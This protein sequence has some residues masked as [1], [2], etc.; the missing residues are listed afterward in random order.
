MITEG[1]IEDAIS[2][3]GNEIH[4]NAQLKGFWEEPVN[5]DRL[6]LRICGEVAELDE[7]LRD[8]NPQSKKIPQFTSAEE[9]AADIIIRTLDLCRGL[10]WDVYGAIRAK[11]HYNTSRPRLHGRAS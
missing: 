6:L 7:A 2:Y 8:S 1:D 4:R 3:L 11:M 10:G 5:V 9:E